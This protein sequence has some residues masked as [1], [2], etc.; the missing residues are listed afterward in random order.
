MT[1]ELYDLYIKCFPDYQCSKDT[2]TSLLK[3]QHA[4][5]FTEY[6]SEK[7]IAY[8]MV[9]GNSIS[10]LCVNPIYRHKSI[11][12]RL[13]KEAESNILKNVTSKILLGHGYHYLPSKSMSSFITTGRPFLF[14]FVLSNAAVFLSSYL[15]YKLI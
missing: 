9:W 6:D 14:N 13:L 7:L 15:K 2:F 5:I 4:V 8:A 3:Q 1:D 12:T 11:G 10:L